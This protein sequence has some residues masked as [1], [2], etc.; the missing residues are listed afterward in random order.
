MIIVFGSSYPVPSNLMG[1]ITMNDVLYDLMLELRNRG[2]EVKALAPRNSRL[3]VEVLGVPL[4]LGVDVNLFSV[5]CPHDDVIIGYFSS[6]NKYG[7]NCVAYDIV[8]DNINIEYIGTNPRKIIVPTD[9]L[10]IKFKSKLYNPVIRINYALNE[11]RVRVPQVETSDVVIP[12]TESTRLQWVI[13]WVNE[14]S[15]ELTVDVLM[16][17]YSYNSFRQYS[18]L[19]HAFRGN[20]NVR[21]LTTHSVGRDAEV[22]RL[23]RLGGYTLFFDNGSPTPFVYESLINGGTVI[24]I[25]IGA[26]ISFATN[27]GL[28][29]RSPSDV[30]NIVKAGKRHEPYTVDFKSFVDNVVKALQL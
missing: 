3:D 1:A 6:Y 10:A 24:G 14:I 17:L 15:K 19:S 23:S 4:T 5:N 7:N 27:F 29:A 8:T 11:E 20:N 21:V 16:P 25:N 18:T 30:V 28:T 26:W 9:S 13:E 2:F 22:F 12:I